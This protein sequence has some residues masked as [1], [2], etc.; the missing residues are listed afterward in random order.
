ML[1]VFAAIML[2]ASAKVYLEEAFEPMS[3]KWYHS[4]VTDSVFNFDAGNEFS[5]FVHEYSLYA[6]R[7]DS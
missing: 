1:K 6:K 7:G 3:N 2:Q 4:R 5:D